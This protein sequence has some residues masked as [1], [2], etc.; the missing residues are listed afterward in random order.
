MKM[1]VGIVLIFF[2]LVVLIFGG[3]QF[4]KY[5]RIDGFI[6]DPTTTEFGKK[7]NQVGKIL[8]KWVMGLL[9]IFFGIILIFNKLNWIGYK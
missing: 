3:K 2:G 7:L 6:F 1:M 9:F 5:G 4:G 8:M